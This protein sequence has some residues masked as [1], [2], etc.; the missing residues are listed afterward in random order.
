VGIRARLLL[1]GWLVLLGVWGWGLSQALRVSTDLA[2]FMPGAQSD[3][4]QL[5]LR[6]LREGPGSRLMLAAIENDSPQTLARISRELAG[7]LHAGEQFLRVE[8]GAAH[9]LGALR[10]LLLD[11]RYLLSPLVTPE[12]FSAAGL[13]EALDERLLDLASPAEPLWR[14]LLPRDPTGE[15]LAIIDEWQPPDAPRLL[16]GVWFSKDGSRALLL[17]ETRAGGFDSDGQ[18]AAVATLR[19]AFARAAAGTGA[20]LQLTGPG[21]FGVAIA[22]QTRRD[23][24]RFSLFDSIVLACILLLAYRAPRL[25]ILTGLPLASGL[26]AGLSV[27]MLVYGEIHGIT[28]AFGST[29][30]GV[31]LDYPVH[32]FSHRLPGNPWQGL[33]HNWPT[34]WT[35][36]VMAC[37]AYVALIF[38]DFPGLAQ[39]GVFTVAGLVTAAAVTRWLLPGLLPDAAVNIAASRVSRWQARIDRWPRRGWLAP[40]LIVVSAALIALSRQPLWENDLS[41]LSP[42]P[43][44]LQ[45]MDGE[46]RQALGTADVR[47]LLLVTAPDAEAALARS[48]SLIPLLERQAAAGVISGYDLAARYLPSAGTQL[49]RRAALPEAAALENNLAAA[50]RASPFRP[51]LFAPFLHDVQAARGR[52]PLLPAQLPDSV[53]RTRV[54]AL[55]LEEGGRWFALLPLHGLRD[56]Q[57]LAAAMPATPEGLRLLDLKRES[58]Q[59]IIGFRGELLARV[60][61]GVAVMAVLMVIGLRVRQ[62]L[63][64]VLLPTAATVLAVV[65]ACNLLGIALSLFHLVAL[66]LVVG[67]SIDYTLYLSREEDD[68][69]GRARSLHSLLICCLATAAA[70]GILALSQIP[71]LRAIGATVAGGVV[72]GLV[73]GVLSARANVQP[74]THR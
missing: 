47:Y 18:T 67:I 21:P 74:E 32:V 7:S 59:M 9:E 37:I 69:L 42:V 55:L 53:L 20:R 68:S 52:A 61:A 17:A 56:P 41:T 64:L 70:F 4:Q 40:A 12:R 50:V 48:E 44:E 16:E 43:G 11:Y 13:G 31:A 6:Q 54:Q 19:A 10:Q 33:R 35:S 65:A 49:A 5:L 25:L 27:V 3:I 62:A 57:Q 30:L 63:Q 58:E 51:D 29:L 46:L 66:M 72:L 71:V 60:A 38:T 24:E 45:Q 34:L 22:E 2:L 14:D 28:L 26:L 73:L 39:L 1:L 8:N 36:V 15:L 23:A